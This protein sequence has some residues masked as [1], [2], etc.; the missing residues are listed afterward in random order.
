MKCYLLPI[1]GTGVRIMKSVVQLCV[2]G[3]FDNI[4]FKVMCID[5]DDVNGDTKELED[6]ISTYKGSN[7]GLFPKM[8]LAKIDGKERCIWSPLSGDR[9]KDKRSSMNDMVRESKLSDDA[10]K[11]LNYLYTKEGAYR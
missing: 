5:S 7:I 1:G 9:Y 2:A 10:K 6:M 11:I 3:Y 4:Q 8:D